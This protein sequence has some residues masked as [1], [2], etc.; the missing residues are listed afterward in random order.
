MLYY[1]NPRHPASQGKYGSFYDIL[2]QEVAEN[3]QS[4]GIPVLLRNTAESTG[5][6]IVDNSKITFQYPGTYDIQFSFQ[7]HNNGGGGG[8]QTVEIWLVQ[9]GQAVPYSNTRVAVNTNSPY[10][11]AAWDFIITTAAG[12]NAQ[13]YW[14]TNNHHIVMQ[15]NTGTMG[16]PAIPSAIVTVLPVA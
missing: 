16:G 15:Y 10:V 3:Q 12:G 5:I 1:W 7:F 8:G 14:A 2:T 9:N 13:I 6:S 11:V 4:I